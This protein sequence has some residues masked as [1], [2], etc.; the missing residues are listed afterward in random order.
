MYDRE[1]SD[2]TA[3]VCSLIRA[4]SVNQLTTESLNAVTQVCWC[5]HHLL[6]I[7]EIS[8]HFQLSAREC[9]LG[10]L[11]VCVCRGGGGGGGVGTYV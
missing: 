2:Q 6:V 8:D 4:F 11:R 7:I 10:G 3:Q 1:F 5:I 9:A